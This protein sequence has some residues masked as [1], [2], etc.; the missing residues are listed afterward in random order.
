MTSVR[1]P[2]PGPHIRINETIPSQPSGPI[3]PTQQQPKKQQ[4]GTG[5]QQEQMFDAAH[6][7]SLR[8]EMAAEQLKGNKKAK[9]KK[10]VKKKDKSHGLLGDNKRVDGVFPDGDPHNK[11]EQAFQQ[12]AEFEE[13]VLDSDL[14]FKRKATQ[15]ESGGDVAQ[16]DLDGDKGV[17]VSGD[18]AEITSDFQVN[19]DEDPDNEPT[20]LRRRP[21][22]TV[23]TARAVPDHAPPTQVAKPPAAPPPAE[24]PVVQPSLRNVPDDTIPG[25]EVPTSETG[26][27]KM[28]GL[29]T[30]AK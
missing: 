5:E 27:R 14:T 16:R 24:V 10:D 11:Q 30:K 8:G 19:V 15:V 22:E 9:A 18:A 2:G 23:T 26:L 20:A 7:M 12:A 21:E 29:K 4:T 1:G 17:V 28:L 6:Q 25:I 3:A 13:K